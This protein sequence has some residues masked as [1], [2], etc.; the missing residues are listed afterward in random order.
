MTDAVRQPVI[1]VGVDGSED[2]KEALRWAAHQATLMHARLR[3]VTAWFFH[4]GYGFPPMFPV[5]Y[6]EPAP[7]A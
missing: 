1:V 4:V 5:S 2:S 7:R 6:E 3:V